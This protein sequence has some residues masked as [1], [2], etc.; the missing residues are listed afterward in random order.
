METG[1]YSGSSRKQSHIPCNVSSRTSDKGW[2]SESRSCPWAPVKALHSMW[3][4]RVASNGRCRVYIS[5]TSRWLHYSCCCQ[6]VQQRRWAC[7]IRHYADIFEGFV[8]TTK[9]CSE[10]FSWERTCVRCKACPRGIHHSRENFGSFFKSPIP[11]PLKYH[12]N[13][14]VLRHMRSLHAGASSLRRWFSDPCHAQHGL[15]YY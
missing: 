14:P 5:S 11:Y 8:S 6:W 9:A 2:R 7:S 15:R 3:A 1:R 12:R 10:K 13:T 4:G